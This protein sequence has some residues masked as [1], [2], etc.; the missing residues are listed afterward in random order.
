MTTIHGFCRRLL[1]AHPVAA[2]L[3]PRFRVLDAAESTRL[4]DQAAR[5]AIA[6]LV[7]G[8]SEDVA[9]AAAS[10]QSWRLAKIA[11]IAHERLRNQGMAHPRLPEVGEPTD[12]STRRKRTS[13]R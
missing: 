1:G 6:S 5:E 3:D 12:L 8:G 9:W 13:A 7:A 10:Y 11:L 2:G 4:R